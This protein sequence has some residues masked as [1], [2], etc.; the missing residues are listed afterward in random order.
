V[1]EAVNSGIVVAGDEV[2]VVDAVMMD[3]DPGVDVV[4]ANC[5]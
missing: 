1:R 5:D 4:G 2:V 3:D